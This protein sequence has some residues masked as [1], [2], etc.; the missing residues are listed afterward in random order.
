MRDSKTS[1]RSVIRTRGF[2]RVKVAKHSGTMQKQ[3][4]G[5]HASWS[6]VVRSG[7]G[8]FVSGWVQGWEETVPS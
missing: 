2:H 7:Y 4:R 6:G 3:A 5:P 1:E 8:Y